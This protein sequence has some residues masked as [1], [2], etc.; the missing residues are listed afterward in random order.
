MKTY[1]IEFN[2]ELSEQDAN[3][4]YK[5]LYEVCITHR[6]YFI[7]LTYTDEEE[8]NKLLEKKKNE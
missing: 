2:S 6:E 5:Q 8:Y 4:L 3:N 7:N 1:L